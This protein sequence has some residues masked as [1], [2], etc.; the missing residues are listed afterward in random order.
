MAAD[1]DLTIHT[2]LPH[3]HAFDPCTVHRN[4][5]YPR[6]E[7]DPV[8]IYIYHCPHPERRKGKKSILGVCEEN[9]AT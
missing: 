8:L 7:A 2:R 3:T 9:V 5:G 4:L 1:P 6:V